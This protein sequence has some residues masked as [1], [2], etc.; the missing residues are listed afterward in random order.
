MSS[1]K[2]VSALVKAG[3]SEAVATLQSRLRNNVYAAVSR[4]SP[5]GPKLVDGAIQRNAVQPNFNNLSYLANPD[6]VGLTKRP[7]IGYF[8]GGSAAMVGNF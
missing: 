4:N 5:N 8:S 6:K 3:Q 7:Q 2:T 1:N